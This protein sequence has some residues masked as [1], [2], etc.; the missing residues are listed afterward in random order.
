MLLALEIVDGV[1]PIG[2]PICSATLIYPYI[3]MFGKICVAEQIGV[4]SGKK[5]VL[6]SGQTIETD[7]PVKCLLIST[8]DSASFFIGVH[9]VLYDGAFK[10]LLP[11]TNLSYGTEN[12][13]KVCVLV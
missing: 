10:E 13:E 5:Y 8:N 2:F 11:N 6:T 9:A 1:V 12:S 7:I 4:S 3:M